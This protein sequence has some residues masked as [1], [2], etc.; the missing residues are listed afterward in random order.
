M[1]VHYIYK[2]VVF[3]D[4]R[5]I[6]F[7]NKLNMNHGFIEN[8]YIP[9][10]VFI[11]G[12][13]FFEGVSIGYD[14]GYDPANN[15]DVEED[16][17]L[18]SV[19]TK[20]PEDCI[21]ACSGGIDSST[22]SLLGKPKAIYTGY[23]NEPGYDERGYSHLVSEKMGIPAMDI[24]VTEDEYINAIDDFLRAICTPIG[25]MGGIAEYICLKKALKLKQYR[26][27]NVLFGNGGDEVFCGYFYNHMIFDLVRMAESEHEHMVNFGASRKN[28][29]YNNISLLIER[30]NRR[31]Y[32]GRTELPKAIGNLCIDDDYDYLDKI[33]DININLT[34]PSLLHLNQQICKSMNVYGINPLSSTAL[35][36]RARG[37][38]KNLNPKPKQ[39][40]IDL[41]PALPEEIKKRNDKMGFP[42]PVHKWL[43]LSFLIK[44][45]TQAA[46]KKFDGINR[47]TW[48]LFMIERWK[49]LFINGK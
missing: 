40:L 4:I 32:S 42:I 13:T 27:K 5:D 15:F 8:E 29:V 45:A 38:N 25:G 14:E 23:Y 9:Y 43:K 28:F 18:A 19:F 34:L 39:A 24:E 7:N 10:Q 12:D 36:R 48:G 49:K 2:D 6:V 3:N 41:C 16:F 1:K 26:V 22:V 31:D 30:L 46:G 35:F 11:S 44:E 37:F 21:V 33:L 17:D 20:V 47:R